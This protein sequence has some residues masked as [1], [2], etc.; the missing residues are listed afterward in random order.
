MMMMININDRNP[1]VAGR[2]QYI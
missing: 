2:G 1:T